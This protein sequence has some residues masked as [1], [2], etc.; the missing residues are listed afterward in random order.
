VEELYTKLIS[1][2]LD[3]GPFAVFCGIMVIRDIKRDARLDYVTDQLME[4]G[5]DASSDAREL[6]TIVKEIKQ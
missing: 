3:Q 6:I 4:I 1:W 2:C 5:R